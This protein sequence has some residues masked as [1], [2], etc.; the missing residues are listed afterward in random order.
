MVLKGNLGRDALLGLDSHHPVSTT[1]SVVCFLWA[2]QGK[3]TE[4]A[5]A[6]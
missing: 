3:A 2:G 5:I 4:D 6:S 1:L